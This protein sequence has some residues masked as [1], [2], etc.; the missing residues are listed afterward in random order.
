MKVVV[1]VEPL[2]SSHD[3]TNF[4]CGSESLD[5]WFKKKAFDATTTNTAKVFVVVEEKTKEILGYFATSVGA[6][7]RNELQSTA[8]FK[9]MKMISNLPVARIGKLAI[10]LDYQNSGLGTHLLME[11]INT[12]VMVSLKVGISVIVVDAANEGL[13]DFYKKFGFVK[14]KNQIENLNYIPMSLPI[15]TITDAYKLSE[16]ESEKDKTV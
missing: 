15:K 16:R 8:E 2:N 13:V 1:N 11:A 12:L 9:P 5:T 3:L 14:M 7:N 10:H 4:K 6:V